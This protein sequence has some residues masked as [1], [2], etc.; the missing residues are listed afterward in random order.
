[1]AGYRVSP[2]NASLDRL[3]PFMLVGRMDKDITNLVFLMEKGKAQQPDYDFNSNGQEDQPRARPLHGS[4]STP[5]YNPHAR[6]WALSGRVTDAETHEAV[7]HFH[8]I[9][10]NNDITW[11]QTHWDTLHG[12]LKERTADYTVY[13]DKRMGQPFVASEGGRLPARQRAAGANA[14]RRM[15]TWY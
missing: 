15:R 6:E 1:M 5:D 11:D 4:E 9:P 7:G 3:N 2:K 12:A 8:V 13:I 10:G 14:N